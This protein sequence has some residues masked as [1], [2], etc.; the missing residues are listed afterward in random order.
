MN[1]LRNKK[2]GEILTDKEVLHYKDEFGNY[3]YYSLQQIAEDWETYRK[4]DN[5]D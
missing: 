3:V 2:T 4:D 1:Y 5:N